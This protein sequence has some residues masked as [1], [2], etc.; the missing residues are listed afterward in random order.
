MFELRVKT[1]DF[2]EHGTGRETRVEHASPER[3]AIVVDGK[4]AWLRSPHA[5]RER[6]LQVAT[7]AG[8][9][10]RDAWI[11]HSSTLLLSL[12]SVPDFAETA[13]EKKRLRRVSLIRVI[14]EI[15]EIRG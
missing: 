12:T 1:A 8:I 9:P 6:L 10:V 13:D 7:A 3:V 2:A 14:R 5:A 11:E 4:L 15:R